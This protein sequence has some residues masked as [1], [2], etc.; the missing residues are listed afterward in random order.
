[1]RRRHEGIVYLIGQTNGRV[2]LAASVFAP[3]ASTTRGS[4]HVSAVDMGPIIEAAS[5][6]GLQVVG[7]LH[8]HPGAAY[9]SEGD[10]E[11]AHIRFDGYVSIV[12]PN[13]G[14]LLPTF[15]DAAIFMFD[16]GSR[17]FIELQESDLVL[18]KDAYP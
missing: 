17:R 13:Y 6:A 3:R 14:V 12:L 5:D 4:F 7:Q 18:L 2:S 16:R 9:H 15:R 11:G 8:T 10:E 1:M